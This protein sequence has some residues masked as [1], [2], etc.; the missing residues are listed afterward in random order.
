MMREASLFTVWWGDRCN[1]MV[2][3]LGI[4]RTAGFYSLCESLSLSLSFS[5]SSHPPDSVMT[6]WLLIPLFKAIINKYLRVKPQV[7]SHG[8]AAPPWLGNEEKREMKHSSWERTGER[9][10]GWKDSVRKEEWRWERGGTDEVRRIDT[11]RWGVRRGVKRKDG[12][13][14]AESTVTKATGERRWLVLSYKRASVMHQALWERLEC[15]CLCLCV[16]MCAC[17]CVCV[18]LF[19]RRK[20]P[21]VAFKRNRRRCTATETPGSLLNKG[22]RIEPWEQ[23]SRK[24]IFSKT[25]RLATPPSSPQ[26]SLSFYDWGSS[27]MYSAARLLPR[28]LL[29]RQ[30]DTRL[31]SELLFGCLKSSCSKSAWC[32]YVRRTQSTDPPYVYAGGPN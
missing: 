9:E 31:E 17:V 14:S 28:H 26:L 2:M 4:R 20:G 3:L 15:V 22:N 13:W 10:S 5:L 23:N 19:V 29:G 30:K 27:A 11:W 24:T 1:A 25:C 32:M 12:D 8:N 7:I 16:F 18:C 21:G 6:H